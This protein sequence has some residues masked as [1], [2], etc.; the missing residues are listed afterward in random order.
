MRQ[1]VPSLRPLDMVLAKKGTLGQSPDLSAL[2]KPKLPRF[3]DT[4][5]IDQRQQKQ[6]SS[7]LEATPRSLG[8]SAETHRLGEGQYQ[9]EER[10]GKATPP[11]VSSPI[12]CFLSEVWTLLCACVRLRGEG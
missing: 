7:A 12:N 10:P 1:A 6:H 5:C 8:T 4:D 9:S 2:E 11:C 3:V